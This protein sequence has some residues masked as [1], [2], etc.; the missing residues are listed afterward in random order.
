MGNRIME[1]I[2]GRNIREAQK[3]MGASPS[4][5]FEERWGEELAELGY[6]QMPWA[7]LRVPESQLKTAEKL[8]LIV[9]ISSGI[10]CYQ[11]TST[12]AQQLGVGERQ[13][14]AILAELKK[15][16]WIDRV[17]RDEG[18]RRIRI[19]D[20]TPA[21]KKLFDFCLSEEGLTLLTKCK[22][23]GKKK[24]VSGRNT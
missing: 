5:T 9:I 1:A 17:Y 20:W 14:Q 4:G 11:R 10:M 22:H 15:K 7:L 6:S 13:A 3:T 24:S 19:L 12:I 2:V 16:G 8:A 18:H 23:I 21:K